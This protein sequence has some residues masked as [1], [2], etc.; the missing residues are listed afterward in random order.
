M[1]LAETKPTNGHRHLFIAVALMLLAFAFRVYAIN[2]FP[3]G[4][5]HDEIAHLDVANQIRSGDWRLLYPRDY[6]IELGHQPLLA[7]SLSI[8]GKVLIAMRLPSLFIGTFGL[9]C[10]YVLAARLFGVRVGLLTLGTATVVWWSILMSR[11][12]LREVLEMPIYALALYGLWRGFEDHTR[13][14]SRSLRPFVLG[15]IALG[16]A[17]YVHTIPRGLFIVVIIFALYLFIFQRTLFKR[18]R[19]GLLVFVIAA[20]IIAAP[21]LIT[22]A[23]SPDIDRLP[24][25]DLTSPNAAANLIARLQVSVP[26]ILGQFAFAGDEAWEFNIPGR[27][28]FEPLG[29]ILFGLGII[30]ALWRLRR[31]AY[32]FA[33]IVL[34]V[35]LLPSIVLDSNFPFTRMISAQTVAFAFVGIGLAAVLDIIGSRITSRPLRQVAQYGLIGVLITIN[36]ARVINDMFITWPTL[37]PMR[38]VYNVELR[39]LD[40]YLN[41]QNHP[42]LIAQC[43]LWIIFPWEPLYH[44]SVAQTAMPYFINR[45]DLDIRWHDCRYSLV[46]PDGGQ[47]IFAHPDIEPL[48]DFL[49]R[50]LKTPWLTNVHPIA[51]LNGVLQ[52]DAR[53][54]LAEQQ[55]QW[56]QL[57]VAWPPEALV[58]TTATLPIDFDHA[59]NLIGYKITPQLVKPG[60]NVAVITYWRVTGALANDLTLFT[61]LYRTPTVVL[62]QQDGL[63]VAPDSLRPGDVFIQQH[64][65]ITV[66]PD[67]LPGLYW[68]GAGLYHKDTGQRLPIYLGDQRAADRIFLTQ[69]QV[70]P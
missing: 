10:V 11:V 68:I 53:A 25:V 59:V 57:A 28:I 39:A 43:T 5:T 37:N 58:T 17:Q 46:I 8:W 38:T 63:D 2:D 19:R 4:L 51:G 42:P 49:G 9:A 7:L 27:P 13:E 60:E 22:A 66:P 29:A 54:A 30:I 26:T 12:I 3:P 69:V 34:G 47:F 67:T 41:A 14:R 48:A 18:A 35:S 33:L 21:M 32:A 15:G 36:A 52:V 31:P 44:H 24:T 50:F 65:F 55:L 20:E 56:N 6:G 1:N 16:I 45:S 70:K 23:L 62:A 64:E 40:R 61:H